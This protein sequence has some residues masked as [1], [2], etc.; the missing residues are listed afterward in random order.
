MK[1][2]HLVFLLAL[3][4]PGMARAGA[5]APLLLQKPTANATHVVFAFADDLWTV[6]RA[7]GSA[8][9]LTSGPGLE[10]DPYF[11]PDGRWVA[12]TGEYEGNLDVYVIPAGGGQP[13]RLTYHPGEDR[14][15]GW[16]PDS[17]SV[18][19]R[20]ERNSYSRFSRLFT[21]PVAGGV[22]QEVPLPQATQGS[23]S[24]DG[25]HLAY[26]SQ[27]LGEEEAR[28]HYR[29]GTAACV[30]IA[31]LSDSAV[32]RVP[33]KDSYDAHPVW[34]GQRVYFLSDRNGRTTLFAYDT[35]TR[36]VEQ[37]LPDDGPDLKWLSAG[38]D[39]LVYEQLGSIGLYDL[40]SG[41][42]R[43]VDVR[44]DA[45]LPQ[46]RP[47]FVA[48]AKY[49]RG[50]AL[51][52]TGL[53][54]AFEARGEILTLPVHKGDARN[55][56]NT[57]GAAERDPA[58]SPDGKSVVYFCDESGV[59]QLHVRDQSGLGPVRK[60]PLGEGS[61]FYYSPRWSPDGK[62]VAFTDNFLHVGYVDL[63]SG[64]VTRVDRNTYERPAIEAAWSP[65]GRWLAYTK[66]LPNHL[67]AVF[68]H[69]LQTGRS[70]QITDGSSDARFPAFDR[71]GKYLYFTAS[72][73]AGPAQGGIEMSNLNYPVTRSVYV[74]VLDRKLPSPLAPESDEEG[75]AEPAKDGPAAKEGAGAKG[76]LPAVA[77]DLKDFDQRI[78]AL[79][80]PARNYV[81]LMPGK[82]GTLFLLELPPEPMATRGPNPQRILHRFDL[83]KR[84]AEKVLDGVGRADVSFN[85]EKVLYQ[86]GEKWF[87]VDT[88]AKPG[89]GGAAPASGGGP[90][91]LPVDKLEV[92]VDPKAEWAQMYHEVWRLERDFLYD[93]T[94]HGIDLRAAE[95]RYLPYLEGVAS[96]RDLNYLFVDML[97]DM[98]LGHVYVGG[99]DVGEAPKVKG[100]LL[101]ADYDVDGGR[102]RFARVYRGENWNPALKAPLTQPG[103]D[104]REGE[105][106][107]S[108]N[109]QD[110]A[111]PRSVYQFF[112]GT[113][114]KTVVLKVGPTP[115]GKGAREVK[116][117]PVQ[118][119]FALRN[120]A[121]VEEN[122]RM[123]DRMTGGR[124]AYVYLPD[125]YVDGYSSFNRHFFA[126][127]GKDAVIIDERF[128]G[129]GKA[130]DYI[131]ERLRRPLSNFWT[132]RSG[133]DYTTP[134]GAIYGPKVMIINEMAGSGGDYLPWAFRR[135]KLGPLVGKRTWGGLVGIGGTPPLIDGGEVTAPYFA[136]YTP[137]GTWEVEG[138][139]VAPDYEVEFDPKAWRD[140]RDPQLEKA[141]ELVLKALQDYKPPRAQRPPYFNYGKARRATPGA[142]TEPKDARQGGGR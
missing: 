41:R 42:A 114:G 18:L 60:Y 36:Q 120:R 107:L 141:V 12:F 2:G 70:H 5:D 54:A 106:L 129:G 68:L 4:A 81:G 92:R 95:R 65:D 110:V 50:A 61:A 132:T 3:A 127:V 136:F 98:S 109:G 94:Y 101:G 37:L 104:V 16:T 1:Y 91:A 118:D 134:A 71:G 67:S 87:V 96:R 72:T 34:L 126:Q 21:V 82:A 35:G 43:R 117:V 102:Y 103:A 40:K 47:H 57:P 131:L 20:S 13:R 84:K 138:R 33:R 55:L 9:R 30:R 73:D 112:E 119:E 10:T 66:V 80:V 105:Y 78:L 48:A 122:R 44:I 49:I 46:L 52:P 19:F 53:R 63:A 100:G 111:P 76:A 64:K 14:V 77:I 89:G 23:F 15:V 139:G 128:N 137:E 27:E 121:W 45:D 7:G 93:P 83:D 62:K 90:E 97:G 31:R 88:A 79:P 85:G 69:E 24:P 8:R 140:K 74:A 56:T 124:V 135:D 6:P 25:S 116:V 17:K 86:Q 59:Y 11:S 125:T 75:A 39:C 29:G 123:V 108:V 113:A 32:E 142:S 51:S 58:W 26:V 28:K 130:A 133:K 99:G 115:D 38:P 22:V